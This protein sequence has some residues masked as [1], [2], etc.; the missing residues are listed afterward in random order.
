MLILGMVEFIRYKRPFLPLHLH[1]IHHDPILLQRPLLAQRRIHIIE[2]P[3][4]T[5]FGRFICDM[6]PPQEQVLR[7]MDPLALGLV[8]LLPI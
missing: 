4:P 7:Y 3:L 5:A 1:E 2:P 6:I 8:L